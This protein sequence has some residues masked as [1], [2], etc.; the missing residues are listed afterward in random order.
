[1]ISLKFLVATSIIFASC[2]SQVSALAAS[3]RFNHNERVALSQGEA[4]LLGSSTAFYNSQPLWSG[5]K[6]AD[7]Q[8]NQ[9]QAE[10]NED[11]SK[12]SFVPRTNSNQSSFTPNK[13]P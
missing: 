7:A 9:K 5:R 13:S 3:P 1:M 2:V 8:Q 10:K 6:N 12:S 11:P 4:S